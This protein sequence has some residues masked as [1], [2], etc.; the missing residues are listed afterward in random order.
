M[1]G[2]R[3]KFHYKSAIIDPPAKC[4]LNGVSLARRWWP[5]IECWLG[6][7][8]IF[9]GVRTSI[10]KKPFFSWF[11]RGSGPPLSPLDPPM[12]SVWVGQN[13]CSALGTIWFM[14]FPKWS[15]AHFNL[16]EKK[17]FHE[18]P[19]S[20]KQFGARSGS[21]ACW[22]WCGSKLFLKVISGRH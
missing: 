5:N 15:S 13:V 19:Q 12:L 17:N 8:V 7:F 6:R 2:E 9:Q 16:F 10:A 21:T 14:I 11:F 3:S 18:Y 20:L 1:R 4:H 22:P